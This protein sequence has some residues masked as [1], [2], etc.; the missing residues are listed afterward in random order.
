L[1]TGVAN[2]Y[3]RALADVAERQGNY[4]DIERELKDFAAAYRE[5]SDL[6]EVFETPA[7]PPEGKLKV[8]EA[9]LERLG[10]SKV[11]SNFLHVLTAHYRMPLLEEIIPAFV[12]ISNDRQGI[13]EVKV[14]APTEISGTTLQALRAS[15]ERVT[16]KQVE[17]EFQRQ[18]DLIGGLL[19]QIRSTVYDGSVRG[20]LDRIR[21]KLTVR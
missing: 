8:L 3:A 11:T 6:R 5:S 18:E 4:R 12:S 17:V 16:G 20:R 15:F 10:V 13:V 1:P 21:E 7:V 19:A 14:F 2:R 9:I